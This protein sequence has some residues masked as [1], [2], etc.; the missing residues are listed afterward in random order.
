MCKLTGV[1]HPEKIFNNKG[2]CLQLR[3]L[4]EPETWLL[5]HPA[6]QTYTSAEAARALCVRVTAHMS[7]IHV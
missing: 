4:W 5:L 1:A 3:A 2:T 6:Q 7:C